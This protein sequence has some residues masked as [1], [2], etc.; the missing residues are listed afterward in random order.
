[1]YVLFQAIQQT[2]TKP[3][4]IPELSEAYVVNV[5]TFNTHNRAVCIGVP[6]RVWVWPQDTVPPPTDLIVSLEPGHAVRIL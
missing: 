1:M 5:H 2:T 3:P 4:T 6:P